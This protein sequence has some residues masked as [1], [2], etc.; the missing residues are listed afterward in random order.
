MLQYN[1]RAP[2]IT[3]CTN[4]HLELLRGPSGCLEPPDNVAVL[5][6]FLS[7]VHAY[8]EL[9]GRGTPFFSS[10]HQV[11]VWEVAWYGKMG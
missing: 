11:A 4:F 10:R 5:A 3:P 7:I 9:R 6:P 2:A 8:D 1:K